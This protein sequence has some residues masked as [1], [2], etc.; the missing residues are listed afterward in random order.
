MRHTHL[1]IVGAGPIGLELAIACK[2]AGIDY[3]QFD[4]GQIAETI[5]WFPPLMRFFS[6]NERIALASVPIQTVDQSKCT[7]EEYL[8]YLRGLVVQFDL[9]VHTYEAV[10]GV[11]RRDG[12]FR[13]RTQLRGEEQAYQAQH[14]VLATGG[15]ARPRRL[16]IPGEDLPHVRHAL[17]DPHRYFRRRLLV[18]GGRNSAVEAA[19]RCHHA[20]ARVALSYRQDS[21]DPESIKYWLLPELKSYIKQDEIHCH[22]RT[23]PQAI[24]PTHVSLQDL[25]SGAVVDV[26]ADEVLVLIGFLA[27]MSLFADAGVEFV[28]SDQVPAFDEQTMQTN[29]PGLYVAGTAAAGTQQSYQLFLENCHIHVDRIVAAVT[30]ASPPQPLE[31]N[32]EPES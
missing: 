15:T 5:S 1:A 8:A 20:F 11:E 2:R 21:F 18:I 14:V 26:P 4:Q 17:G 19:M 3:L 29:V 12:G 24:T 32:P 22:Y 16:G 7:R 13:L 31:P 25:D 30:G 9:D 23:Q 6:S 27:D 28:G 10:V